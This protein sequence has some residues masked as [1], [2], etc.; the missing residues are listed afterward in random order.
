MMEKNQI[1]QI[2]ESIKFLK[3][4]YIIPNYIDLDYN[5]KN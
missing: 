2:A 1:K 3:N 4:K 5:V